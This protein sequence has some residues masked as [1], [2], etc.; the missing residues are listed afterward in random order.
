MRQILAL[1]FAGLII[2]SDQFSKW[3]VINS[4]APDL[5]YTELY[6]LP[7]FNVVM[8]WNRGVSFGMFSQTSHYG[9]AALVI[10]SLVI[11][12]WFIIWLF[13]TGDRTLLL[14]ISMVIGGAI[15]NVIDRLR[16][17]AVIDFLDFHIGGWHYPAFNLA[18]SCIVLG[19]AILMIY[20]LFFEKKLHQPG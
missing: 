7:F 16:F 13:R 3:V 11:T 12:L 17:G 19:V 18:D 2:I 15:G 9:P 10:L 20:T 6:I 5:S 4:I 8:V 14:G 1:A